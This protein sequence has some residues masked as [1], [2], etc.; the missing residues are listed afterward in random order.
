[1]LNSKQKAIVAAMI[2]G[3]GTS[4]AMLYVGTQ[5]LSAPLAEPLAFGMRLRL[6]AQVLIV[7]AVFILMCIGRLSMHRFFSPADIDGNPRHPDSPQAV[8]LQRVL[9][10]TLEQGL[11]AVISYATWA[12]LA[13]DRWLP[14]LVIAAALFALGRILFFIGHSKGAVGRALGFTLTF[15]PTVLLLMTEAFL[16]VTQQ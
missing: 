12:L 14:T 1:V 11:L 4:L 3:L 9:Q 10:N 5:V 15:Y 8:E 16:A 7:P 2:I 6:L 13:P